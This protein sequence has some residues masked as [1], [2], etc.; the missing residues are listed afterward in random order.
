M[1]LIITFTQFYDYLKQKR[2]LAKEEWMALNDLRD[3]SFRIT[4]KPDIVNRHGNLNKMKQLIFY[5]TKF[6]TI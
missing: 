6:K 5:V 3:D 2:I 1:L 4:T